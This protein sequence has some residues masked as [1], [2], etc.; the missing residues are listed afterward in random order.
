[1]A[2]HMPLPPN[3]DGDNKP[4][5]NLPGFSG[6]IKPLPEPSRGIQTLET[7]NSNQA[8]IGESHAIGID[9]SSTALESET[10]DVSINL[11]DVSPYQPRVL[12]DEE[13]LGRLADTIAD[14][15]LNNP[16]V[17]RPKKGG[18]FELIGGER[19][20]R[21]IQILGRNTIPVHI[22]A[23]GDEDAAIMAITDND[24]REDL[25]DYERG[26][27]YRALLLNGVIKTQT[28]LARRVGVSIPTISRCLAY[29]KLPIRVL[30]ML[31]ENPCLIGTTIVAELAS[32]TEDGYS[33]L[34]V[35]AVEK[36]YG[37]SFTQEQAL[38]WLRSEIKNI[39]FP[40]QPKPSRQLIS[41]GR[42][43]ADVKIDGR[44]IILSCPREVSPE[45]L[46]MALERLIAES[47]ALLPDL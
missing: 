32:D 1:M 6:V 45:Q 11:I 18:R 2:K 42:T 47:S 35:E 23:I 16:I 30:E 36:I 28:Q 21:A 27:A 20:L 8:I 7:N 4:R 12:F 29:F 15:G 31:D 41:A 5:N 14:S 3:V 24:A 26:K 34:V 13:A 22:R 40:K 33:D 43:L 37:E 25:S 10:R 17:V 19:R 39:R 46:A 9:S 44:K 38:Y